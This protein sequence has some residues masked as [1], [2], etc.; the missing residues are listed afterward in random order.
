MQ[1][2]SIMD[3][4]AIT[5][6]E[7]IDVEAKSYNKEAKKFQQIL[8]KNVDCKTQNFY[9]L[10]SF[11]LINIALLIAVTIYCYLIQYRAKQKYLLPFHDTNNELNKLCINNINK[12]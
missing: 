5:C 8:M 10:L 12:K 6:D 11:F 7:I 3:D 2:G 1:L 9:I 4:S